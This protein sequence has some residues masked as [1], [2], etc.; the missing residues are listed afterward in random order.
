V[1]RYADR[2]CSRSIISILRY[3][4][5]ALENSVVKMFEINREYL[6]NLDAV[7]LH[8]GT[9][10]I[11]DSECNEHIVDEFK[12]TISTIQSYN[13][14]VKIIV[15]S[16]I[17]RINDRLMNERIHDANRD[18]REMCEEQ[19]HHFLDNDISF[20]NRRWANPSLYRDNIHL[21]PKGG[22]L[23]GTSIRAAID[24]V[25]GLK[26]PDMNTYFDNGDFWNG[27]SM[28]R[29]MHYQNERDMVFM[30]DPSY[31][32]RNQIPWSFHRQAWY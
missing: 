29:Q 16:I 10:N 31:W 4:V 8:V 26:S 13:A 23:L 24:S 7:V 2:G 18:L 6:K 15:S 14:G 30:Q 17:P 3:I 22:K 12:D 20:W 11:S 25:L 32:M 19:G 21:N 28:G 27:R 9:N 5:P 1:Y